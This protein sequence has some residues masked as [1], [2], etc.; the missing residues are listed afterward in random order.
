MCRVDFLW[1]DM[2]CTAYPAYQL[3]YLRLLACLH[4]LF[5]RYT[6]DAS[7]L[8]IVDGHA[9]PEYIIGDYDEFAR[10]VEPSDIVGRICLRI[11]QLLGFRE[12]LLHG[13]PICAHPP[14]YEV[15]SPVQYP[16]N[17]LDPTSLK[18]LLRKI[19][20]R[21]PPSHGPA[22]LEDDVVVVRQLNQSWHSERQRA[23]I[24]ADHVSSLHH[25]GAYVADPG[26]PFAEFCRRALNDYFALEFPYHLA[27][28]FTFGVDVRAEPLHRTP[29]PLCF[30]SLSNIQAICR[31][32]STFRV[33]CSHN[34]W[35]KAVLAV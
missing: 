11:A 15:R 16:A 25:G 3:D 5:V 34:L 7:D 31:D 6:S 24:G 14:E 21:R 35:P 29:P 28:R 26:F 20:D 1:R 2:R 27:C 18:A 23:L 12:R 4:Y 10:C 17:G 19:K 13:D 8:H 33:H 9:S 22:E 30:E 32:R